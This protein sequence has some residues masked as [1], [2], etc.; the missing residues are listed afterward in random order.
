MGAKFTEW[1]LAIIF[2]LV[3]AG[4][5]IWGIFSVVSSSKFKDTALETTAEVI[6]VSKHTDSDGDTNYTIYVSYTIDGTMYNG[7]Y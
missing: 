1:L 7:S 4:L 5:I 3:G 6:S 2:A